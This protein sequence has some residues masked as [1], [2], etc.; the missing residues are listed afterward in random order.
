MAKKLTKNEFLKIVQ[1]EGVPR[2]KNLINKAIKFA[3]EKE[4]SVSYLKD[5]EIYICFVDHKRELFLIYGNG[6]IQI[7]QDIATDL[8]ALHSSKYE[9]LE[10]VLK[11]LPIFGEYDFLG[12][13]ASTE[14]I[15][16][17]SNDELDKFLKAIDSV[18]KEFELIN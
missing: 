5:H 6:V 2:R 13:A 17:L 10:S 4:W 12:G 11:N 9:S 7:G 16:K 3:N 15:E 18:S 1:E 8:A 14:G